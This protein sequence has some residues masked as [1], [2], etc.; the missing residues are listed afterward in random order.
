VIGYYILRDRIPFYITLIWLYRDQIKTKINGVSLIDYFGYYLTTVTFMTLGAVIG[1]FIQGESLSKLVYINWS[2]P[3]P[4]V[5]GLLILAITF[6]LHWIEKLPVFDSYFF[7]LLTA[8]GGGWLYEILYG[9]PYWV[10][11]GFANWNWIKFNPNFK[12]FFFEYQIFCIPLVFY[13]IFKNYNLKLNPRGFVFLG[14]GVIAFYIFGLQIAP[15]F[16][17]MGHPLGRAGVYAWILRIPM[18]GLL[19]YL[20]SGVTKRFNPIMWDDMSFW[21]NPRPIKISEEVKRVFNK[22]SKKTLERK[23]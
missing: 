6:K 3:S 2:F 7:S 11:S 15:I 8:L 20:V 5:W 14:L 21:L 19:Y 4:I 22:A 1:L 13:F 17:R 16:H 18:A 12:V 23:N 10:R 9:F